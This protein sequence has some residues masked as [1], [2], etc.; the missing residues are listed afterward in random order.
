MFFLYKDVI[1]N[2]SH[3]LST[4]AFQTAPPAGRLVL[5]IF[6]DLRSWFSDYKARACVCVCSPAF[7]WRRESVSHWCAGSRILSSYCCSSS[8]PAGRESW[9][10]SDCILQLIKGEQSFDNITKKIMGLWEDKHL[11][12][13]EGQKT[14]QTRLNSFTGSRLL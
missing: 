2:K 10:Q 1:K 13:L 5:C 6:K 8:A 3:H 7:T 9:T 14:G 12:A 4:C 11:C